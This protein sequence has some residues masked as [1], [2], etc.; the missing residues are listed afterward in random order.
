MTREYDK[1]TQQALEG[2]LPVN[3][4]QWELADK[5]GWSVA[6]A[7]TENGSLPESFDQWELANVFGLTVAHYAASYRHLP[8]YFDRW[9]IHRL[10]PDSIG[11]VSVL[12]EVLDA[13]DDKFMSLWANERPR[14]RSQEDWMEFKVKLPEI[15]KYSVEDSFCLAV[16]TSDLS[17][18][19]THLL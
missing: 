1:Y 16:S 13:G 6:H 15:E 9:S 8:V 2:T 10:S 3:F 11:H 18:C 14:C 4:N 7:A 5:Y 17:N 19:F 12:D